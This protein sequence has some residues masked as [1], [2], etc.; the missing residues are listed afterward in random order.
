MRQ[1]DLDPL[2]DC[3]PDRA[4]EQQPGGR[5]VVDAHIGAGARRQRP[6]GFEM[7]NPAR[8]TRPVSRRGRG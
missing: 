6:F 7:E 2:A 4:F 5:N 1:V 3:Q 8:I